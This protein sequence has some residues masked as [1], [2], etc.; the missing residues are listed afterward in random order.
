MKI[1][2]LK[3][4]DPFNRDPEDTA[5]KVVGGHFGCASQVGLLGQQNFGIA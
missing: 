3:F 4:A 2:I 1:S 5:E